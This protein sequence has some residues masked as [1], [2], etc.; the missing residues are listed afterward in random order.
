MADRRCSVRLTRR[1]SFP[2]E[3]VWDALTEPA[4]L[5]RWLDPG[6]DIR[7]AVVEPGRVLELDW[8][9]PGEE[10]SVV[11]F[12]LSAADG[13]TVLVLDHARIEERAGMRAMT[14]WT[15]ALHRLE[16]SL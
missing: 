8:R 15:A 13:G 4:S 5:A 3:E 12:E 10:P 14:F 6:F 2:P 1:Y 11:R 9:P 16:E 7:P